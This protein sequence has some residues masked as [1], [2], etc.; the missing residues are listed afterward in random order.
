MLKAGKWT[1]NPPGAYGKRGREM[2]TQM[3]E[4]QSMS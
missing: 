3:F 2:K 4:N 1:D